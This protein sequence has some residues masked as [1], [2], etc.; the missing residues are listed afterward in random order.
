MRTN[1][2]R[3]NV[4]AMP[5]GHTILEILANDNLNDAGWRTTSTAILLDREQTARLALQLTAANTQ[6][7]EAARGIAVD[8]AASQRPSESNLEE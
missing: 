7:R 8:P 5:A 2:V 6:L 3:V 4:I 1:T